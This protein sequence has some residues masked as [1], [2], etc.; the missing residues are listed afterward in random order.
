MPFFVTSCVDSNYD[1][2]NKEIST[3]VKIEG[4]TVA[5]PVGSLKSVTLNDLINFDEIEM[6]AKGADGVYAI[7]MNDTVSVNEKNDSISLNIRPFEYSHS[8]ADFGKAEIKSV[9][10][11]AKKD[12]VSI[13]TQE[14]S[15]AKLNDHLPHLGDT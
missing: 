8:I 15:V 11:G 6:L 5:L 9:R 1:V 10:I 3:D 14:I 2:L 12:S 7:T 13:K 4:N